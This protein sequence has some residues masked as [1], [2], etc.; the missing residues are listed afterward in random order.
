MA[1][2][3]EQIVEQVAGYWPRANRDLLVGAYEFAAE[4]H[5]DQKR[6]SGAPYIIHPL[7]V[8]GI[9]AD[10]E[11]DECSIAAGLLHDTVEDTDITMEDIEE[12]FGATVA[13]LVDG[14]TKLRK[15]DF[16]SRQEE[17]ARNL[18]KMLLA[19]AT[20]LRVLL[21]K[22]ADRLHNMRTLGHLP[23]EKR[24]RTAEETLHI[25]APLCHRLGI[26]TI[27]VEM[28]DLALFHLEPEAYQRIARQLGRTRQQR[29][30]GVERARAQLE[31]QLKRD[32]I[33]A[34][35]AGRAKHLYSIHQKMLKQNVDFSQLQDLNAL[36]VIARSVPDCYAVLGVVHDVWRPI[37]DTFADYIAMPKSNQYQS[38]HTKVFGP[39][40]SP[41]EIQIRTEEMHRTAEYGMASHWRYKEDESDSRLDEQVTWL[42]QLLE[43]QTDLSESHEF[44]ELLQ[45]D[46]FRDQVFVFTPDGMV[47]DL[48]AGA[49]PLDFA[50]RVHTEVGHRCV[51]AEVNGQRVALDYQLKTGDMVKIITSPSGEPRHDWLRLVQSSHAKAK[52]RRFLREKSRQ[53]NITVGTERLSGATDRLLAADRELV[54]KADWP[55]VADHFSY[56]DR[57]S[58]LA[59]IGYGMVDAEKVVEYIV[60]E[61][62]GPESLVEEAQ[63]R[64]PTEALEK[65]PD[66][67]RPLPVSAGGVDG[68]HSR[69]SKC[70]NPLPG[71]RIRGYI[72][73]GSGLAIHRAEC[74][75]LRYRE[76]REPERIVELSWSADQQDAMLPQEIEI[77]ALDRPGVLSHLTAI[78]SDAGVNIAR[79]EAVPTASHLARVSLTLEINSRSA[80][81][82]LMVR[83]QQLI[84]VVNV[85][86]LSRDGQ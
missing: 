14:V 81:E 79:A 49:G 20:D 42:R 37:P 4:A 44:L 30:A 5:A 40:H 51:G 3:I 39:D 71:D 32:G 54:K 72:T 53:E 28:E 6:L 36:R 25:F 86:L 18:R 35:V 31:Q 75:N 77:I 69:L 9:L 65:G 26:Q 55:E 2:T 33:E 73:R 57:D 29:E 63:R 47:I 83:L 12:R 66:A 24:K 13:E 38:L 23:P 85:R 1:R 80:L 52:V 8:A 67:R 17:Q 60:Q 68:F 56:E 61:S 21:M 16:A 7:E 84:D 10:I 78:I 46:L 45:I 48:P 43:L 15:L 59:A 11:S 58:L 62:S 76:Q 74:K 50:Y 27:R 34:Q 41:L 64:L 70:C 82:H 22:L 19:M